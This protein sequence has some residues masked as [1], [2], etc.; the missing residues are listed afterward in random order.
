MMSEKSQTLMKV[1]MTPRMLEKEREGRR[2]RVSSS[3]SSN[4][5]RREKAKGTGNSR[6]A[7]HV[8]DRTGY[9][10]GKESSD[11]DE[12]SED[13][14]GDEK[15]RGKVQLDVSPSSQTRSSRDSQ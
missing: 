14:L 6:R 2:R 5:K 4:G 10:D 13:T 11:T 15:G 3:S 1:W 9:L 12:E 7:D 8:R